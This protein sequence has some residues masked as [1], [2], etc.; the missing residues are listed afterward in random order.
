MF[1]AS[2]R[3]TIIGVQMEH[4]LSGGAVALPL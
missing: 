2:E 3:D 4:V 1:N